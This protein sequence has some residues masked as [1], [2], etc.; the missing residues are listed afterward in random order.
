MR[1]RMLVSMTAMV[2]AGGVLAMVGSGLRGPDL[3]D[4][5]RSAEPAVRAHAWATFFSEQDDAALPD[6][7][8][9]LADASD[10]AVI[11]ADDR[12]HEAGRRCR[13]PKAARFH[14]HVADARLARGTA[15]DHR[16]AVEALGAIPRDLDP[17]VMLPRLNAALART[18]DPVRAEAFLV[19]ATWLGAR[20]ALWNRLE[21]PPSA[22]RLAAWR[23]VALAL[24]TVP[25]EHRSEPAAPPT[26]VERWRSIAFDPGAPVA[27]TVVGAEARLAPVQAADLAAIWMRD[28][29]EDRRRAGIMLAAML[30]V[31]REL[32]DA[33]AAADDA[34]AVRLAATLAVLT[35]EGPAGYASIASTT[36]RAKIAPSDAAVYLLLSGQPESV[37]VI[38]RRAAGQP[39]NPRLLPVFSRFVP[40][41]RWTVLAVLPREGSPENIATGDLIL[42]YGAVFAAELRYEPDSRTY[43]RILE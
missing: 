14:L 22:G 34:P 6:L 25:A 5:V 18:E 23:R 38:G 4:Q 24:A 1:N 2:L 33:F 35:R 37:V 7:L 31:H 42:L 30:D 3:A 29:D 12:I 9:T 39:V 19:A 11:D 26:S 43:R 13:D 17:E 20:P 41:A 40:D 32:V 36:G 15:A 28:Y 8:A 16:L 10:E 27:E 21:V